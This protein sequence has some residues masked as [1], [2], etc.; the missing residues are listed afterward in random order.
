[1]LSCV[2]KNRGSSTRAHCVNLNFF[3]P[4]YLS[5]SVPTPLAC[6]AAGATLPFVSLPRFLMNISCEVS[7]KLWG[8]LQL[9]L[10]GK[11]AKPAFS[12]RA[13]IIK[14]RLA[15]TRR[16]GFPDSSESCAEYSMPKWISLLISILKNNIWRTMLNP[17]LVYYAT[18]DYI[19]IMLLQVLKVFET[20]NF[21]ST[22]PPVSLSVQRLDVKP[23]DH[24]TFSYARGWVGWGLRMSNKSSSVCPKALASRLGSS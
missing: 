4:N 5:W 14:Q 7:Y 23:T 12:S 6:T 18:W 10:W 22:L 20:R 24:G 8:L 19:Y 21:P 17:T 1:M 15:Q 11:M 9:T 13:L 16:K 2:I 3:W